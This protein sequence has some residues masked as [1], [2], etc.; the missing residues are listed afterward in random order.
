MSFREVVQQASPNRE[1]LS[2]VG[3][4]VVF[5]GDRV[6]LSVVGLGV[7]QQCEGLQAEKALELP[8]LEL[9][10]HRGVGGDCRN[11]GLLELRFLQR[12]RKNKK[13]FKI[14]K[15]Q[16]GQRSRFKRWPI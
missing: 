8:I 14:D 7:F 12:Q 2:A 6:L 10:D 16:R 9:A 15:K 1:A 5:V 11:G 4:G 13:G 3:A